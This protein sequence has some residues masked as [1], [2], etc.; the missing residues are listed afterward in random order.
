MEEHVVEPHA[1]AA[2]LRLRPVAGQEREPAL[3]R[4]VEGGVPGHDVADRARRLGAAAGLGRARVDQR[5]DLGQQ[6]ARPALGRRV[7]GRLGERE[8]RARLRLAVEA[9]DRPA[10]VGLLGV[11]PVVAA[12]LELLAQLVEVVVE[13][14]V[15]RPLGRH[16]AGAAAAV[17]GAHEHGL[18]VGVVGRVEA[19]AG[20]DGARVL[21]VLAGVAELEQQP[22]AQR[23]LAGLEH[24][25]PPAERERVGLGELEPDARAR[26][27]DLGGHVARVGRV[28]EQPR[29]GEVGVA[30]RAPGERR[31]PERQPAREVHERR[32]V[33]A[34]PRVPVALGADR[35]PE[36]AINPPPSRRTLPPGRERCPN[37]FRARPIARGYG[38]RRPDNARLSAPRRFLLDACASRG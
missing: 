35:W 4:V 2:E 12:L 37:E 26:Q 15:G 10:P 16:E 25:Q 14:R 18:R 34:V 23:P 36:H 30:A 38:R 7:V 27:L 21:L 22:E 6:R 32:R 1:P 5:L 28:L 13:P 33:R 11:G 9:Q 19:D 29:G 3:V 24:G 31:E 20:R 17:A 8:A